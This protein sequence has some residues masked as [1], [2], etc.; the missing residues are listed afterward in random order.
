MISS[1]R[2][3]GFALLLFTLEGC[4]IHSGN[5]HYGYGSPLGIF[6]GHEYP[7]AE[8]GRSIVPGKKRFNLNST[9]DSNIL[10]SCASAPAC[11][12]IVSSGPALAALSG[13]PYCDHSKAGM[14]VNV[15]DAKKVTGTDSS[16]REKMNDG[17]GIASFVLA[18]A[19]A[20]AWIGSHLLYA[21][22][23]GFLGSFGLACFFAALIVLMI[24]FARKTKHGKENFRNK[25]FATTSMIMMLAFFTGSMVL[26]VWLLSLLF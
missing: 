13:R 2:Y 25:G 19:T 11:R 5:H 26:F 12:R 6:N 3:A 18:L 1:F 21:S 8:P 10:I 16:D 23:D 22:I 9:G 24:S 17:W 4:K 15:S 7:K 14:H 20:A